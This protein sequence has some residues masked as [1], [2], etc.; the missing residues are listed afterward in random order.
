MEECVRRNDK[1]GKEINP[2]TCAFV[3][4]C[5]TNEVRNSKGQ[6]AKLTASEYRR[7][8]L[9]KLPK[10]KQRTERVHYEFQHPLAHAKKVSMNNRRP[11]PI[12]RNKSHNKNIER[13]TG[14]PGRVRYTA[15][16]KPPHNVAINVRGR[17]EVRNSLPELPVEELEEELGENIPRNVSNNRPLQKRKSSN[18]RERQLQAEIKSNAGV[19]S[20]VGVNSRV[21]QK[22]KAQ[23]KLNRAREEDAA[24]QRLQQGESENNSPELQGPRE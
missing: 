20:N 2:V 5:K 1:A 7:G 11:K 19:K 15:T 23:N 22:R 3:K 16:L 24:R 21:L 18:K 10:K 6:C 12:K 14:D 17:S 9:N 8:I 13:V 4:K